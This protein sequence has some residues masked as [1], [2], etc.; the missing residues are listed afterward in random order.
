MR[1][2][3]SPESEATRELSMRYA[4]G[5]FGIHAEKFPPNHRFIMK[6]HEKATDVWSFIQG[7]VP[8]RLKMGFSMMNGASK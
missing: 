3:P 4:C 1:N 2:E 6:S 8:F 7:R 5:D